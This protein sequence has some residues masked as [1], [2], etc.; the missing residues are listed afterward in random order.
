MQTVA[1][2][3]LGIVQ[4]AIENEA[5]WI[6]NQDAEDIDGHDPGALRAEIERQG[7]LLEAAV[8]D[9]GEDRA[10]RAAA[11]DMAEAL[12]VAERALASLDPIDVRYARE[13]I[14]VAR[15]KAGAAE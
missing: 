7:R 4:Q 14:A 6:A 5:G 3:A 9:S 1:I 8:M 10:M 11:P 2:M 15:A 13:T 12:E